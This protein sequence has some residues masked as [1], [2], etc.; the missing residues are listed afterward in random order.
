MAMTE[1]H[2]QFPGKQL[3][4]M[5]VFGEGEMAM[6]SHIALW[7]GDTGI[8]AVHLFRFQDGM[9]AEMWDCGQPVPPDS[10]NKDGAF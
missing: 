1:N 10:P 7:S 5:N 6:H 3:M 8:A 2:T 9:I 4:V